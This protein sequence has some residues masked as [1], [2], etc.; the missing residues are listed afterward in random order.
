MANEGRSAMRLLRGHTGPIHCLAVSP[1]GRLLVSGG[2]DALRLWQLPTGEAV[3]AV[4]AP[5]GGYRVVE[6]TPRDDEVGTSNR[7]NQI[8]IWQ[9]SDLLLKESSP[10]TTDVWSLASG[11][12]RASASGGGD[13]AIVIIGQWGGDVM[14]G[15][16]WPVTGLAFTPDG[17]G[18]ISCSHDGTVRFWNAD[19]RREEHCITVGGWQTCLALS[20]SGHTLAV[21]AEDGR[22]RLWSLPERTP[23]AEQTAHNGSLTSLAFTPDGR[24]LLTAGADGLVRIWDA[25]TW[26]ERASFAWDVGPLAAVAIP[27]DG[28]TAFVGGRDG[29]IVQFDLE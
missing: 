7:E 22:V 19:W 24:A 28:M 8:D 9:L 4:A 2:D 20:P 26:G 27:P 16:S 6:I 3:R 5:Q 1:D 23:L 25:Q 15:H 29:V 21:G 17:R 18:L 11:E 10:G 14:T 13:G 12:G